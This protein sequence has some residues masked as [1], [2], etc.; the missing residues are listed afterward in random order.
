MQLI[1]G[2]SRGDFYLRDPALGGGTV[3]DR[4]FDEGLQQQRGHD[5]RC[6]PRIHAKRDPQV[7]AKARFL[8]RDVVVQQ[9]ELLLQCDEGAALTVKR[10]AQELRQPRD[11]AIGL[12]G[13]LEHEGRDRVEGIEEEMRLELANQRVEPRLH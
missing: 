9:L 4:V 8:N 7:I 1:A 12:L 10:L 5:C 2:A 6:G 11:H 3:P 13:I